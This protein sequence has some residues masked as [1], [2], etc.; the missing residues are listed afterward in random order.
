MK[1]GIFTGHDFKKLISEAELSDV[2][3]NLKSESMVSFKEV[4][5]IQR[6]YETSVRQF[7]GVQEVHSFDF[8]LYIFPENLGVMTEEQSETFYQAIKNMKRIYLGHWD[9][10]IT[11]DDCW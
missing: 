5:K 8:H 7:H 9:V 2:M 3:K 10:S 6:N 11:K 4:N 1:L